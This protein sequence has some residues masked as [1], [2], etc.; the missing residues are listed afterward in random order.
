MRI[1]LMQISKVY[2]KTN[3]IK[4]SWNPGEGFSKFPRS[5]LMFYLVCVLFL[6]LIFPQLDLILKD[7]NYYMLLFLYWGVQSFRQKGH[8]SMSTD[9]YSSKRLVLYCLQLSLK[10]QVHVFVQSFQEHPCHQGE[11][12]HCS[13]PNICKCNDAVHDCASKNDWYL[14]YDT[15]GHQMAQFFRPLSVP[16]F[17]TDNQISPF[18][19]LKNF[20]KLAL[21]FTLAM[22]FLPGWLSR[23]FQFCRTGKGIWN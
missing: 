12:H 5:W 23:Y 9:L 13:A 10:I 6:C 19:A 15:I 16:K 22:L 17:C 4:V 3:T 21:R 14:L 7:N 1:E 18:S 2:P 11:S 8:P 20:Q